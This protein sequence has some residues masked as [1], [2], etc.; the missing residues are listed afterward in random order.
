MHEILHV[1]T[2]FMHQCEYAVYKNYD[3]EYFCTITGQL[4]DQHAKLSYQHEV[5]SD[6]MELI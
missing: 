2:D 4:P 3:I 6:T 1:Y 5:C